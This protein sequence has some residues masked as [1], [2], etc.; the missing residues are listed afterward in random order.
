MDRRA[1]LAAG[2]TALGFAATSC[3]ARESDP[4]AL[5]RPALLASL[6]NDTVRAIGE[7]YRT[8]YPAE[9]DASA[10]RR[11]ILADREPIA[12]LVAR[13]FD[14]GR[15]VVID[16]WILSVTEARQCALFTLVAA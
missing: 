4:G 10:L 15:V 14:V 9:R 16:G 12:A 6:G 13:D 2:A 11:A 5:A 7:R 3:G 1:F 8:L